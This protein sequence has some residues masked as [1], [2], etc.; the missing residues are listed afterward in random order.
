[1]TNGTWGTAIE[2]PGSGALNKDGNAIVSSVSCASAGNC[3]AGGTYTDGSRH[4]QAVV[5]SE[6]NGSRGTGARGPCAGGRIGDRVSRGRSAGK[7]A[8]GGTYTDGSGH[9]QAF[10]ASQA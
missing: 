5:V 9:I 1:E 4:I 6:A 7:C 2:V 3:A 10:V 8:A